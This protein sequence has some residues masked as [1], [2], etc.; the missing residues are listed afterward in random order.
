MAGNFF[1]RKHVID[2]PR[3]DGLFGH[4]EDDRACLVLGNGVRADGLHPGDAVRPI[5]S[6]PCQDDPHGVQIRVLGH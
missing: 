1:K 6:H 2:G 4:A 3:L 5:P